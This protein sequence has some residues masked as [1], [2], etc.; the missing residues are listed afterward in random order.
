MKDVKKEVTES[1]ITV[2][3]C[4]PGSCCPSVVVDK[5]DDNVVIGGESEG[6]AYFTKEE[7]KSFID[8]V[9]SGMFDSY[10]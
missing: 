6:F 4:K 7:F 1:R 8:T 5:Q 9:K 3:Y 2:T 10:L